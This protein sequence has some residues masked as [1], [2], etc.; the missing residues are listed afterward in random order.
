M[1]LILFLISLVIGSVF[2]RKIFFYK[3]DVE[4]YQAWAGAWLTLA[5]T[6]LLYTLV[7][8]KVIPTQTGN[9]SIRLL[10]ILTQVQ[11]VL[12][13]VYFRIIYLSLT[14]KLN[15][16]MLLNLFNISGVVMI[17]LLS[18]LVSASTLF[19]I[20]PLS[21]TGL[22]FADATNSGFKESNLYFSIVDTALALLL[23][24][25]FWVP[26]VG[27]KITSVLGL[28]NV[29]IMF[30]GA[31]FNF[32]SKASDL[33]GVATNYISDVFFIIDWSVLLLGF[34]PLAIGALNFKPLD[35]KERILLIDDFK[36]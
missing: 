28:K 12:V 15:S 32:I 16:S 36:S 14:T 26:K 34:I 3:K 13:G 4:V 24:F 7:D 1:S 21:S 23:V 2:I 19:T 20:T 8:L 35:A 11:L 17:V 31:V 6:F 10:H 22:E 25:C 5:L 29:R 18:L 33:I 27:D 30:I 9:F